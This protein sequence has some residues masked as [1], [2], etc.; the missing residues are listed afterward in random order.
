MKY[1]IFYYERGKQK[2]VS[3]DD[4]QRRV[5]FSH[6]Q[7]TCPECGESVFIS[8]GKYSYHF[9]HYSKSSESPECDK[10]VDGRSELTV[11]ERI[12]LPLY[13]KKMSASTFALYMGFWSLGSEL[14]ATARKENMKVGIKS[15]SSYEKQNKGY[16]YNIDNSRFLAQ[17]TTYLPIG[18]VP[19]NAKNYKIEFT[20]TPSKSK[21]QQRW[22]DYADGFAIDGAL[23]SYSENW[24][25]KVRR[26]D[27][28]I[29]G[30]KYYWITKKNL[31]PRH[32]ALGIKTSGV[33]QVDNDKFYV[34]EI[35]IG[36]TSISDHAFDILSKYFKNNL[37]V[38]LLYS[39]PEIIPLWPPSICKGE[40]YT[41][42]P[43]SHEIICIAKTGN[44]EPRVFEYN[45]EKN[46]EIKLKKTGSTYIFTVSVGEQDKLITVDRKYVGNG[47][48]LSRRLPGVSVVENKVI[49]ADTNNF[50][51]ITNTITVPVPGDEI[52]ISSNVKA[53]IFHKEKDETYEKTS[54]N[55][56]DNVCIKGL[57][58]NDSIIVY[59]NSRLLR[60]I[61]CVSILQHSPD[62][63]INDKDIYPLLKRLSYGTKIPFPNWLREQLPAIRSAPRS[64]QIIK[65]YSNQGR[66]PSQIVLFLRKKLRSML[67]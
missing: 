11:Y 16:S 13:I 48:F 62:K 63:L 27:P 53:I 38:N 47:V 14:L 52:C 33:L 42:L 2:E 58:N 4:M 26:G 20:E 31:I 55:S 46:N 41:A 49:L 54:I 8:S 10:R 29:V 50:E 51:Y 45:G 43:F 56:S 37:Q 28:V 36:T 24:G 17:N 6:G 22:S 5:W 65:G 3:A 44:D 35:E 67:K 64:Y 18:F 61:E 34:F 25:K 39:R 12:G 7:L 21:V 40:N 66:I 57:K 32:E 9:N 23:F 15:C 60:R 59:S 30:E 19:T 1:A